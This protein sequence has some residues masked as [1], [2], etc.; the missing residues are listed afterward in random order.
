M[1]DEMGD[2]ERVGAGRFGWIGWILLLLLAVSGCKRN[3]R[4]AWVD[5]LTVSEGDAAG[6]PWLGVGGNGLKDRTLAALA[7]TDRIG[8]LREGQQ[9]PDDRT[10]SAR[11]EVVYLRTLPPGD[12]Q[13][14]DLPRQRAEVAL[15]ISLAKEGEQRIHGEGRGIQDYVAGD[16]D[17]R[18]A[19]WSQALDAALEDAASQLSFHFDL[20]SKN[21]TELVAVLQGTDSKRRDFASRIL[22]ERGSAVALPYLLERLDDADRTNQLRAVG[23]LVAIKDPRAVPRLIEATLGRDPSFVAQIAYALGE[24]GGEEAE[25]YLFTASTGH[26]ETRVRQ[27]AKEALAGLRLKGEGGSGGPIVQKRAARTGG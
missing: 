2:T 5:R 21:E 18:A 15:Q 11:V 9:A 19:A 17:V 14:L 7:A 25:A 8:V 23:S 10:W 22:A 4:L 20:S 1:L 27:A 12:L 3:E 13:A 6:S 24:I 26:P 16:P